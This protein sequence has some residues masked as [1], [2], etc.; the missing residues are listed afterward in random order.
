MAE[1]WSDG[2]VLTA[3]HLAG[4]PWGVMGYVNKTA[5]QNGISAATDITSLTITF[6]AVSTRLY[7]TTLYLPRLTQNTSTGLVV[8]L[9]ADGAS[10]TKNQAVRTLT[11]T[12]ET[13]VVVVILETGL[14]GS[15]TRKGRIS[16]TAGTVDV[17]CSATQIAHILVE[18]LGPA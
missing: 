13:D 2:D 15:V 17:A 18:D 7:R 16:T 11:A 1:P 10:A 5:A 8:P 9:I 12:S 3:A 4:L 14:S 6:T